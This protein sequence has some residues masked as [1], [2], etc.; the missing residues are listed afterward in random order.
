MTT[1][2]SVLYAAIA[3]LV[4]GWMVGFALSGPVPGLAVTGM[5]GRMSTTGRTAEFALYAVVAVLAMGSLVGFIV[6]AGGQLTDVGDYNDFWVVSAVIATPWLAAVRLLWRAWWATAGPRLSIM[7]PPARLLAAAVAA[8]P[9]ERRDWGAAMTAELTQVGDRRSRWWFAAGCARAAVLPPRA[10]RLPVVWVAVAAATA[11]FIAGLTVGDALPAMRVFAVTFVGLVGAIA[12]LALAG[13]RRVRPH[14]GLTVAGLTCVAACIAAT[15]Y[16]LVQYPAAAAHLRPN[17]AVFL[18]AILAV[19]VWLT[20]APPHGLANDRLARRIAIGTAI[21]LAAGLVL[22][23]RL[24]LRGIA[25]FDSGIFGYLFYVPIVVVFIV[26]AVAAGVGR[27]FRA[28]VQAAVWT[29]V[30][31]SLAFYAVAI[32][33]AV[34]WY[35]FDASL[36]IMGDGVPLDAVGENLRNFAWGLILFPFWWLPFGVLGAA[37]MGLRRSP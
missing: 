9:D 29:A 32:L 31:A 14:S 19:C 10:N 13:S 5:G 24:G 34:S 26:S 25:G 3:V 2:E 4:V 36:I 17:T 11:V 6:S 18:A 20:L 30:L 35:R 22:V 12:V 8:L 33:E 15:G 37:L 16:F 23:S 21:A 27:S 1:G 7:D 28:G